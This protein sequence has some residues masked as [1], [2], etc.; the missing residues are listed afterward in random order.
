MSSSVHRWKAERTAGLV[1]ITSFVLL[2][3]AGCQEDLTAFET[4]RD[5]SLYGVLIPED[6]TQWVRVFPVNSRLEPIR[7]EPLDV[8]FTSTNIATE[9]VRVWNDSLFQNE[10]GQYTHIFWSPFRARYNQT[11]R[12]L[13]EGPDGRESQVDVPVPA[14]AELQV[15]PPVLQEG[16]EEALWLPVTL[17][18]FVPNAPRLQGVGVTYTVQY[19]PDSTATRQFVFSYE[20]W[21]EPVA[22]GRVVGINLRWAYSDLR[23]LLRSTDPPLWNAGYGMTLHEMTLS[24]QVVNEAWHPPEGVFDPEVLVQPG[25]MT[26][27]E[28][29]FGFVGA[30]FR[31]DI[32]LLPDQ[33]H[34]SA[35]LQATRFNPQPVNRPSRP[36][37]A[38]TP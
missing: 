25:L 21:V 17:P 1:L 6:D 23:D 29:G 15:R 32:T 38:S 2:L 5:Y 35:A 14:D 4:E 11:Y 28:E 33:E 9:E 30:G 27:I 18:I 7:P 3:S 16:T 13:V 31:R 19:A 36:A 20:N 10:R 22:G 24:V 26:N 34:L 12:L 37:E 8:R